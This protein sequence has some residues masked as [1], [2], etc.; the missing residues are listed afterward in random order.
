MISDLNYSIAFE[1]IANCFRDSE[2]HI[3]FIFLGK[4]KPELMPILEKSGYK[5]SFMK[6]NGGLSSHLNSLRFLIRIFAR[7]KYDIVHCH[8]FKANI[9]GLFA[10]K[11]RGIKRRIYTRHHSTF[12]HLYHPKGVLVDKAINWLSTDIIAISKNVER[13]L[14]DME[15]A[16]EAKVSYIPHGF[17]LAAFSKASAEE[18]EHLIE[19]YNLTDDSIKI[20]VISRFINWKGHQYIIEAFKRLIDEREDCYLILA[21]ANGPDNERIKSRLEILPKDSYTLIPFENNVFALY[22]LFDF[23]VHVPIDQSVEA[24]GQTYVEA[25]AA[26]KACVFTLSG[27]APKFVVD[28]KNALVVPHKNSEAVYFALKRLLNDDGLKSRLESN[29]AN[30]VKEFGLDPFIQRLKKLYLQ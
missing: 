14:I 29:A 1:W 10:A 28:E 13:I 27:I 5:C 4:Q 23:Y 25:L 7:E 30:S 15:G 18:A 2:F 6:L 19:K 12:H 24:F 17:D 8:L 20:G 9:L 3:D 26:S 21:N 22:Q 16:N 11:I